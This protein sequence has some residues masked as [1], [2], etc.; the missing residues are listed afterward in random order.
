MI[1][2]VFV[3]HM[4]WTSVS[5]DLD[6]SR[7]KRSVLAAHQALNL[8]ALASTR[9]HE[10]TNQDRRNAGARRPR[11]A[12]VEAG[13]WRM[14]RRL[15]LFTGPDRH[16]CQR[17]S[18]RSPVTPHRAPHIAHCA[19]SAVFAHNF[20][21]PDKDGSPRFVH[22]FWFA[23]AANRDKF[24]ADPWKFAPKFGGF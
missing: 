8:R 2:E 3:R 12:R 10:S 14:G 13:G 17:Y 23:S 15:V 19:G 24:A 6:C 16:G 21:S 11:S 9:A 4:T 20:T 5:A 1:R 18:Q 22:E 7:P